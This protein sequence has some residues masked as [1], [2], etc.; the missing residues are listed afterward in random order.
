MKTPSARR[1]FI[2]AGLVSLF[3]SYLGVW[4]RLINDPAERT[5]SD[6]IA[7]YSAG[8]VAQE[9]G[10]AHTYNFLRQQ[11]VQEGEVGFPL[12][13]RQ[14][15]LY[16]HLPFLLPIL[17]AIMSNN[18]VNSFYIWV[19]LLI[20]IYIASI[21]ILS[22][23][24]NQAGMDQNSTLLTAIGGFLFLP[25][26][27]SLMNGQDTA[28]IFLGAAI[29]VHGLIS[30][31]ELLAGIGLGLTTVRPHIALVLS[32]PMLFSHRKAF[33][34]F[35]L[36]AGTLALLSVLILGYDGTREFINILLLS[37]G[38]EWHGMKESAMFN[39]IGLLRR[40]LPMLGADTIRL[41]GWAVYGITIVGMCV[42]W[43]KN[44][45]L[46]D[47]RIGLTFTLGLFAVPHLHFHDLTLLLIPIY[48]LIRSNA[49]KSKLQ[50]KTPAFL[51]IGISLLL[52]VSNA[53][54]TLQY[55]IP[56][57]IML[58]LAS[59][60]YYSKQKALTTPRRS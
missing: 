23:G 59:Y 22:K 54:P 26:F 6:F 52:L 17:R 46:S 60:P 49:D 15:L 11:D 44:G 24:L 30:G 27:F 50:A 7:F 16:N 3:I 14:V 8:R 5:G 38:G 2:V 13:P 45:D 40:A 20:A 32:M 9:Y 28:F 42:L 56:Y 19:F 21:A 47:W 43:G 39:L 4:I 35:V 1:I 12:A 18:Y 53:S 57:L 51:P 58:A 48:E 37:V 41:I 33:L 31:R 10:F 36:S 34:G 55:T 25:L 29:W